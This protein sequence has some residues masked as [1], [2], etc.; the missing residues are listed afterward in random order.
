MSMIT[1]KNMKVEV[2]GG[3]LKAKNFKADEKNEVKRAATSV[4]GGYQETASGITVWDCSF[5]LYVGDAKSVND[6]GSLA[7]SFKSGDLI[8][9]KGTVDQTNGA[10]GYFTGSARVMSIGRAIEVEGDALMIPVSCAGHG[11]FTV[12]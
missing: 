6:G 1:G 7:P 4:S 12:T 5:D 3:A 11:A 10:S 8:T 2:N 9:V